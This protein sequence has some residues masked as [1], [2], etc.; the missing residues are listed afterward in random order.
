MGLHLLLLRS[1][2]LNVSKLIQQSVNEEAAY[3]GFV[4]DYLTLSKQYA[5]VSTSAAAM[6]KG[7]TVAA[8]AKAKA[9]GGAKRKSKAATP[10]N[11][12]GDA[13]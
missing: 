13:A 9:K 11:S 10:A 8:K 7:A 4:R 3:V 2:F 5:V 12:A 1:L 6:V